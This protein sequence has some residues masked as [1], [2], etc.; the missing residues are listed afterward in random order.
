VHAGPRYACAQGLGT[1][2]LG[3]EALGVTRGPGCPAFRFLLLHFGKDPLDEA[4]AESL[5][6]PLDA[7]DVDQVVAD[8]KDHGSVT[9]CRSK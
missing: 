6:G 2:L 7:A 4:A 3:G 1:G 5:Q 9:A 8:A